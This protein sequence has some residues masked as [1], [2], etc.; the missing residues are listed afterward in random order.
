MTRQIGTVCVLR[1]SI[2]SFRIIEVV[3]KPAAEFIPP[4]TGGRPRQ[5]PDET[6]IVKPVLYE[7][8]RGGKGHSPHPF[9]PAASVG[10]HSK[11]KE[12][13]SNLVLFVLEF[14]QSLLDRDSNLQLQNGLIRK[15]D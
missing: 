5:F 14:G 2:L 7:W 11:R 3:L 4:I 1:C 12:I 8:T 9:C 6:S 13:G 10:S 15:I